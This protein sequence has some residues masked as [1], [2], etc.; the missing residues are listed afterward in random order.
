MN[1]DTIR[2]IAET[3]LRETFANVLSVRIINVSTESF[4]QTPTF[5]ADCLAATTSSQIRVEVV[6]EKDG[7]VKGFHQRRLQGD[8]RGRDVLH[9]RRRHS[10][11]TI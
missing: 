8:K 11:Y 9:P 7:R 3:F 2:R 1:Y 4:E 5:K 6:I 10:R